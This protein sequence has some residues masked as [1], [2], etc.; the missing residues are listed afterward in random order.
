MKPEEIRRLRVKCRKIHFE[1]MSVPA[2]FSWVFWRHLQ[3]FRAGMKPSRNTEDTANETPQQ[4]YLGAIYSFN[5][6]ARLLF[7][8]HSLDL[9]E[10]IRRNTLKWPLN[11]WKS[12]MNTGETWGLLVFNRHGLNIL[13]CQV[14]PKNGNS[15]EILTNQGSHDN[16]TKG[17]MLCW[18]LPYTLSVS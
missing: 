8:K 18:H 9:G 11:T 17:R 14:Q 5:D 10:C 4:P 1:I 3:I 2:W 12:C 6:S 13:L 7:D 15:L 16:C